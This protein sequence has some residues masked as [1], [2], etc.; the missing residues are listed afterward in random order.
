MTNAGNKKLLKRRRAT[1]AATLVFADE[2]QL[3]LL[4]DKGVPIIAVAIPDDNPAKM[5]F[6]ATTMIR[7]DWQAYLD[8]NCDLRYLFTYP[9]MRHV[10]TF[11]YCT[12]KDNSVLMD[13]F[14]GPLPEEYLPD[15]RMFA[16]F[17]TEELQV[18]PLAKGEEV[19]V[20]D[21]EWD[22]PEF[23]T[24]YQRYSDVYAFIA[25]VRNYGDHAVAK[26]VKQ[27]IA[28]TFMTKPFK[29]GFSYVHF[30][31]ELVEKLMRSQRLGLEK[32]SYAS[33]GTVEIRGEDS[34][35]DEMKDILPNYLENRAE[36]SR[37]YGKLYSYLSQNKYLQMSAEQYR[38]IAAVDKFI[39]DES[40]ILS[41]LM[42][43]PDFGVV[44]QLTRDHPLVSAKIILAFCRRLEDAA[45]YFAQGRVSYQ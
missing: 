43:F 45:A 32:I 24:F 6:A 22:M 29:G 40:S 12:L 17:H 2:P 10:Y 4:K 41:N 39:F 25:A 26:D 14:F 28:A 18:D 23:G 19:L 37:Q 13:P 33:P 20:V 34:L 42:N 7:R 21:G 16:E 31:Q 35:F 27:G 36:I 15:P 9:K 1:F 11:D 38:S 5:M 30:F 8:G 44:S 3:I